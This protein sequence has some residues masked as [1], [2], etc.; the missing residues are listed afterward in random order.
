VLEQQRQ[1][2]VDNR[3][4][5]A[6]RNIVTKKVLEPTELRVGLGAHRDLDLVTSWGERSDHRR[7]S[8]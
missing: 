4:G 8:P 6:I 5:I 2:A 1:R 3:G 7:W